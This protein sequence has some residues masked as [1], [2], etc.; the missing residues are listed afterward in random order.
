M[1]DERD[2]LQEI[3]TQ[4][5]RVIADISDDELR[6]E[7]DYAAALVERVEQHLNHKYDDR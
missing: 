6:D 5:Q 3:Q 2:D 1:T 4:L 7:L